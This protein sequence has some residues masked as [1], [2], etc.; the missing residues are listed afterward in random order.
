MGILV[1][2]AVELSLGGRALRP[3]GRCPGG[4]RWRETVGTVLPRQVGTDDLLLS[5]TVVGVKLDLE[6]WAEK[7]KV[8]ASNRTHQDQPQKVF[9]QG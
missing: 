4:Q 9:G 1:S 5:P 3:A 7:F 2:T 8:L 6:A